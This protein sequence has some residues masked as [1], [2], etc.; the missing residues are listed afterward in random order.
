MDYDALKKTIT[1]K[2]KVI[3][4]ADLAVILC[5]YDKTFSIVEAKRN[6]FKPSNKIQKAIRRIAVCA[7][8]AHALGTSGHGK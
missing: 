7:N 4:P 1:E 3:I 5:D 8:V 6:L 2:T